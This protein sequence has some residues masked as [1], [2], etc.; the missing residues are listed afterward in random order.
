MSSQIQGMP[1][2]RKK[3]KYGKSFTFQAYFFVFS[4]V[5][6]EDV[7]KAEFQISFGA[8]DLY[9]VQGSIILQSKFP[10]RLQIFDYAESSQNIA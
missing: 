6:L 2:V 1:T 8:R 7:K 10:K 5:V 3:S 4:V 9:E